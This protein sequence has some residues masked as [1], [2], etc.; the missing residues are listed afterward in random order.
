[1][2]KHRILLITNHKNVTGIT[3]YRQLIPHHHLIDVYPEFDCTQHITIDQLTDKQLEK[4][5]IIQL[6]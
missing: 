4:F 1:M 5:E 2:R 6:S 3:Y